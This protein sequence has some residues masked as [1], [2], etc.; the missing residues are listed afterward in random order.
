M[1][2][3][4]WGKMA[5]A[6]A[7]LTSGA[8]AEKPAVFWASSPVKPGEAVMVQGGGWGASPKIELCRV[9]DGDVG[10]PGNGGAP[11]MGKPVTLSSLHSNDEGLSFVVPEAWEPGR[12]R[13]R[14]LSSGGDS[15]EFT[16][17]NAPEAWWHQGDW[18]REASPG[19]WLRFFGNSLGFEGKTR[20]A[21]HGADGAVVLN[22]VKQDAWALTVELP[23]DLKA[24]EYRLS[25]HNGRG[26]EAGWCEAGSVRVAPHAPLW[27]ETVYDIVA[28]GAIANDGIDDT[29]AV[30]QAL[31][32]AGKAGGGTVS[33]PR[34][35]FQLN[36]TLV[37]PAHVLLKGAGTDLSLLYWRDSEV[38]LPVLIQGD[39]AFGIEEL[40]VLA[41]NH[42]TGISSEGGDVFMRRVVMR[43]NRYEAQDTEM[44]AN[45]LM[46][47]GDGPYGL[48]L[49]GDNIQVVGCSV[50]SSGGPFKVS[51]SDIL[52]SGNYFQAG[53]S[54]Y[55]IGGD[56]FVFEDNTLDGSPMAR[57]GGCYGRC[58]YYARNRMGMTPRHDGEVFT[59]DGGGHTLV[60][61]AALDGKRLTMDEAFAKQQPHSNGF[62]R[63]WNHEPDAVKDPFLYI[64]KGR[65]A[66]QYRRIVAHEKL[67]CELDSPWTMEPDATS[68]IF[69]CHHNFDRNLLIGNEFHDATIVQSYASGTEWV[70]AGNVFSRIGGVQITTHHNEPAWR[71]LCL[72]NEI[73]AGSN[74]RGPQSA[75]LDQD[76]HLAMGSAGGRATVFRG[77]TLRNNSR[78]AVNRGYNALVE[79]NLICETDVGVTVGAGTEGTVLRN[80]RFEHV[81][82]PVR[83]GGRST[84]NP[85]ERLLVASSS[86]DIEWPEGAS[87]TFAKLAALAKKPLD[88]PG[89]C[90][91]TRA[92]AVE[93]A[94]VAAASPK[95]GSHPFELFRAL[96]VS[97]FRVQCNNLKPLADGVG[98]ALR[99]RI[100]LTP[101]EYVPAVK[102]AMAFPTRPGYTI[103]PFETAMTGGKASGQDVSVTL[104]PGMCTLFEAPLTWTVAGEGW[105]LSGTGTLAVGGE[106]TRLLVTQWAVCGPFPNDEKGNL[107]RAVRGPERRLD[108]RTQYETLA[109][110][111]GWTTV[112]EAKLEFAKLFGEQRSASAFALAVLRAK[113]PTPF[114]LQC[115]V[116]AGAMTLNGESRLLPRNRQVSGTLKEGDNIVLMKVANEGDV[117]GLSMELS[118]AANAAPGDVQVVPPSQFGTVAA[119]NPPARPVVP[120]GASLPFADGVDWRLV[121]EDDFNRPRLGTDWGFTGVANWMDGGYRLADGMIGANGFFSYFTY[122][123]KVALPLRVE[124]D[125]MV[126]KWGFGGA[127]VSATLTPSGEAYDRRLWGKPSGSGYMLC[128]GWHNRKSDQVWRENAEVVLNDPGVR[129]EPGKW[130]RVVA[131]FVPPQVTMVVD[132]RKTLSFNDPSWLPNLD[133]FTFFSGFVDVKIDNVRIYGKK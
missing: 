129:L 96:F 15:S 116:G 6:V 124:Y 3:V 23:Q 40:T 85:A 132:G 70:I 89:L 44:I 67:V 108:W 117:W 98:G 29:Y 120:E 95:N 100:T 79:A 69:Y 5:V 107:D 73:R 94:K 61:V 121:D 78:I 36:A 7:V 18:G 14:V 53:D 1:R 106:D 39:H 31:D 62:V 49:S 8:F 104:D 111:K 4:F 72:N 46:P 74:Y 11:K 63:W 19:G 133:T 17:L 80:N 52:M 48:S 77:N 128:L 110:K 109:G 122:N 91:E 16:D 42:R 64:M 51:G 105:T 54:I 26:G 25:V 32:A 125:V 71:F 83:D 113:K 81:G 112:S 75:D 9:L 34:G 30:Q 82:E 86:A 131:Q 60:K 114:A 87:A 126:G 28:Y 119:L 22:P 118:V 58:L 41:C 43:L 21:L 76:A 65:G 99:Q 84:M 37:L 12:Y 10:K 57:G 45:R 20:V 92:C 102:L 103:T 35:R 27:K 38:A 55:S 50:V 47:I 123:H 130:H 88:A 33:I 68:E 97:G 101:T 115:R 90:E 59:S 66:G 127:L 2:I 56:R 93:L 13:F 24:G